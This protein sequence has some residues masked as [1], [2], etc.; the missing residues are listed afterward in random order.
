MLTANNSFLRPI[1]EG[2][3]KYT[4][5]DNKHRMSAIPVTINKLAPSGSLKDKNSSLEH[6]TAVTA[7][8]NNEVFFDLK[9]ICFYFAV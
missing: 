3:N 5:K 2:V 7:K 8:I 4:V 9:Y 1:I 6:A